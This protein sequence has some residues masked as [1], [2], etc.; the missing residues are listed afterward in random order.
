MNKPETTPTTVN[1]TERETAK[2]EPRK[3]TIK[4]RVKAGYAG[5]GGGYA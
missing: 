1:P 3:L 4:S 5:R 2:P